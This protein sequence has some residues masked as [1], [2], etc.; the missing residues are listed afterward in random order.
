MR[1]DESAGAGHIKVGWS[2]WIISTSQRR[3]TSIPRFVGAENDIVAA[4]GDRSD[5]VEVAMDGRPDAHSTGSEELCDGSNLE[6]AGH[7]IATFRCV[8]FK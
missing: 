7:A 2:A 4:N 3:A 6:A 5:C 8:P 1:R